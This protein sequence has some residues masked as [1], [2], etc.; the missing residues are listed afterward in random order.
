MKLRVLS[1]TP[2]GGWTTLRLVSKEQ[3]GALV[4]APSAAEFSS[5]VGSL[6][7]DRSNALMVAGLGPGAAV[8]ASAVRRAAGSAA[9]ELRKRGF[10]KVLLD[11]GDWTDHAEAAV[12][13]FVLGAYRFDM[14]LTRRSAPISELAVVVKKSDLRAVKLAA[15]KGFLLGEAA[16]AARQIAN[17]PGNVIY[18][19]SLAAAASS[20]A[21]KAGLRC[22]ILDPKALKARKFGGIL[23]VGQG[24]ARGPRLIALEHLAGKKGERPL[25]L[26]GKAITFDTGGISIKPGANM[27]EMIFDKC[28]GIAVLGAMQAIAALGIRRNVV[29][30]L[31][32]AENMPSGTAYRPGDIITMLSGTTV[33]IV[34]TDAE[35]RMVLGDAL[36]WARTHYK[37]AKMINLA[38]LTGACGVALADVNAGLWSN[39]EAFQADVVQAAREAGERLW[40]MP[41]QEEYFSKI[42]SQVAHMKNSG[43]R[44]GGACT[45]AAF[46]NVFADKT[47]WAHVDIAYTAHQSKDAHGLASGATGF[48]VR[49][50]VRLA[51]L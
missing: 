21:K 43:G 30:L 24:S 46:L 15:E 19:E 32:A 33:E 8:G 13:G 42:R 50:L 10:L 1:E 37:A 16:N 45:A 41:L 51:S 38:T 36:H 2:A 29:G 23:A 5:S 3:A 27:E 4:P 25:V 44:L 18:P 12:E 17:M 39:D 11:L 6:L 47:P 26:V 31:A 14:F 28:G 49:T 9:L 7:F 34:N 20:M 22:R 48:G 35:G 40:P